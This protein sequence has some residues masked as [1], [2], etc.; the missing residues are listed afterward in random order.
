MRTFIFI[1]GTTDEFESTRDLK[2]AYLADTLGDRN[3]SVFQFKLDESCGN[4][5]MP[6]LEI[7][8]LVGRGFAFSNDWCMDDTVSVLVEG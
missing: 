4:S 3:H 2:D 5:E 8:L 1:I 7:A 6:L